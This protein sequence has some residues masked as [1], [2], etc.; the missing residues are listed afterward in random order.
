MP[1]ALKKAQIRSRM[2]GLQQQSHSQQPPPQQLS[3][4]PQH[5][6]L[7]QAFLA[8]FQRSQKV[9]L[10]QQPQAGAQLSQPPQPQ[11]GAIAATG[12]IGAAGMGS[13]PAS[14]IV[15]SSKAAFTRSSSVRIPLMMREEVS[16]TGRHRGNPYRNRGEAI[17]LGSAGLF[18]QAG[19]ESLAATQEIAQAASQRV[20]RV[21]SGHV[22]RVS[23]VSGIS[24]K[25]RD[26][27]SIGLG[28]SLRGRK[29]EPAT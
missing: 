23:P 17:A 13:A 5:F 14:Q 28:S 8:A 6:G 19:N 27:G 20:P 25:G 16:S 12:T 7:P 1:Q 24:Q 29:F 18:R 4:Q 21:G 10:Q 3:Q 11:P 15:V 2:L 9:G 26:L 22:V